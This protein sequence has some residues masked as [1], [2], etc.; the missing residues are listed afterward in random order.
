LAL[1]SAG[2][3]YCQQRRTYNEAA[4]NLLCYGI[5]HHIKENWQDGSSRLFIL[6]IRNSMRKS[7]AM[8]VALVAV[9]S[10]A[11]ARNSTADWEAIEL[12]EK[13]YPACA[14]GP[15]LNRLFS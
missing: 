5:A 2:Y 12:A 7:H 4:L 9:P 10:M 1:H 11:Q 6:A 14:V 13:S 8:L 15:L 3:I